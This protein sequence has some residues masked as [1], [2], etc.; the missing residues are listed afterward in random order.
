MRTGDPIRL[1]RLSLML[2]AEMSPLD[3]CFDFYEGSKFLLFQAFKKYIL[4]P[5]IHYLS[6]LLLKYGQNL[7]IS[8][9]VGTV[10]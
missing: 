7:N 4:A 2:V 6:F 1:N 3:C 9:E 5:Y 10:N 8:F